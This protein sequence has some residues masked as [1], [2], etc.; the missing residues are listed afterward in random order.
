MVFTTARYMHREQILISVTI[1][2]PLPSLQS[3]DLSFFFNLHCEK[4][5]KFIVLNCFLMECA[6]GLQS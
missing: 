1:Q 4:D 6:D 2:I 3:K 5:K